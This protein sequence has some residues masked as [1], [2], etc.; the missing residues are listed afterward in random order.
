MVNGARFLTIILGIGV[1]LETIAYLI[2]FHVPRYRLESAG[3][4]FAVIGA[5]TH[6]SS[7][8]PISGISPKTIGKAFVGE[9]AL[10][11]AA[12]VALYWPSLRLGPLSDDF[13]LID[14]VHREAFGLVHSEFFRPL[15]LL[16]WAVLLRAH[17]GWVGLHLLNVVA[18]GL[19]AFLASRLAAPLL[20]NRTATT[21]VGLLVITF[22]ASVEAVSWASGIFDVTATLLTLTTLLVSRHYS[23]QTFLGRRVAMLGCAV[24]ALLCK[25]TAV[26]LPVLI[27]LDMWVAR[28][29]PR[30]LVWDCGAIGVIFGSVG[31]L[32]WLWASDLVRRPLTKYMLQRWL[33]GT[34]AGVAVP[35]HSSVL[36]DRP[37]IAAV[38]AGLVVGAASLYFVARSPWATRRVSLAAFG[39]LLLGTLPTVTFFFVAP[40]L[41]GSRYLYLSTVGFALLLVTMSASARKSA[42]AVAVPA[43]LVLLGALGVRMHQS[44]WLR[45]ATSRDAVLAAVR[46]DSAVHSCRTIRISGLPDAV[47]GAYVFRNGAEVALADEG[48]VQSGDV[49]ANCRFRWSAEKLTLVALG[50]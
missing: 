28:R 15:P 21:A 19:V 13:V 48:L 2:G 49:E 35:W 44:Q 20:P 47:G 4:A 3:V 24:A 39:W 26:V 16:A 45:A 46:T 7:P 36:N 8:P 37:W 23:E 18:H 33:F 29:W 5:I 17:A 32:R 12:S 27:A 11:I 1:A 14:R 38:G 10:W 9:W 50:E 43:I 41:E 40:D 6:L 30:Q 31:V 42:A 25:E 34:V 22:P